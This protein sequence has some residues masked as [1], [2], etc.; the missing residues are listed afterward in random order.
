MAED[1]VSWQVCIDQTLHRQ[2][3]SLP[4]FCLSMLYLSTSTVPA[5]TSGDFLG[6]HGRHH[7]MHCVSVLLWGQDGTP[8]IVSLSTHIVHSYL[9]IGFASARREQRQKGEVQ[10]VN[11][12]L[13]HKTSQNV[14]KES[15]F[16]KSDLLIV[17]PTEC[18]LWLHC[19]VWEKNEVGRDRMGQRQSGLKEIVLTLYLGPFVCRDRFSARRSLTVCLTLTPWYTLLEYSRRN[20]KTL[21]ES[22]FDTNPETVWLVAGNTNSYKFSSIPTIVCSFE[23][24]TVLFI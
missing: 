2:P 3:P 5:S 24:F 9:Q 22:T 19:L 20:R 17:P 7:C 15:R 12:S 11:G 4:F 23:C 13:V 18:Q 21:W 16:L 14:N 10:V 6:D 1:N 8:R